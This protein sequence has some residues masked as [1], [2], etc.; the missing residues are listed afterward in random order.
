MSLHHQE[1]VQPLL[2][3][4][5]SK[6]LLQWRALSSAAKAVTLPY[7]IILY[8]FRIEAANPRKWLNA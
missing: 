1:S 6:V 4:K 8:H 3:L 7:Q 2:S 5:L